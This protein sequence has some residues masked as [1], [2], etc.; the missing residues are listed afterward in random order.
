MGT[1]EKSIRLYAWKKNYQTFK[2][3][4]DE[5]GSRN[6]AIQL[7]DSTTPINLANC[8]VYF[9]AEKP[10][11]TTSYTECIKY[12]AGE[13][14]VG[15]TLTP[16]M[17]AVAGTVNCF[18]Q[19]IGEGK[20][21]LRFDGMTLEVVECNLTNSVESATEF[22]ALV[23]VL[24]R[25]ETAISAAEKSAVSAS[26]AAISAK[27]A[28]TS[29]AAAAYNA[30]TAATQATSASKSASDEALNAKEAAENAQEATQNA[31]TATQNAQAATNLARDAYD[32]AI[33]GAK[34]VVVSELAKRGQL[35]PE[36]VNSLEELQGKDASLLYVLPDGF[37]YACINSTTEGYWTDGYK[38]ALK[39]NA[40][41]WTDDTRFGG[42]VG[43]NTDSFL[44]N[45]IECKKGD[46][47]HFKNCFPYKLKYLSSTNNSW[48][49]PYY[50]TG[51]TST[52]ASY[53]SSVTTFVAGAV[54]TDGH[55]TDL[56]AI[57]IEFREPFN[58]NM[59][60]SINQNI[61][62][63]EAKYVE[64][65]SGYD[66]QNTGH[67]F[68]PA[69]YETEL[70]RHSTEINE[71]A[72]NISIL[73]GVTNEQDSR[74]QQ[75][76]EVIDTLE[77]KVENV[78][79]PLIPDYW[80]RSVDEAVE[81][82]KVLQA[83]GGKDIVNFVWF[84]DLHQGTSPEYT[85]NIGNLCAYLMNS[86]D[87]PLTLMS[88]DTLTQA[89]LNNEEA[90]LKDLDD[91][92]S[93]FNQIGL[94]RLMLIRGNHDDVYGYSG[95]GDNKVYYVNKVAPAKVWNKLHRPQANDFRKVFGDDGTY[96]Y[97]DNTP[98]KV[99]FICLNSNFYEGAAVSNGTANAMTFGFGNAQLDWLETVA[100]D[101]DEDWSVVI[102][103]H[104]PV[105]STYYLGL[106]N[107]GDAFMEIIDST[108]AHII[109]FF[110]GHAHQDGIYNDKIHQPN[111]VITCSANVPYD[112][113]E[114]TAGKA[115]DG[116][117][118]ETAIDIVSIDKRN[119]HIYMTRLGAGSD[120]ATEY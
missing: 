9:H 50:G 85:K 73:Q 34:N 45:Y 106:Y 75:A 87:I 30:S 22:S 31:L 26:T 108:S 119:R 97:L 95:S 84:S 16:Q 52:P 78:N 116:K 104:V 77:Q 8:S 13:G 55:T 57:Q 29:A 81:K 41:G 46:I 7:M 58:N 89:A 92:R 42:A 86:C 114:R 37:I 39:E 64:G 83:S 71:N 88:G 1:V 109:A 66:W 96:F 67:A 112:G 32:D 43:G 102:A 27:D 79:V 21:D 60:V 47:I 53:D 4:Q 101:V 19:V 93:I 11:S 113:T 49:G 5:V 35:K 110:S 120:R 103:T 105:I 82:V 3:V 14:L 51:I 70:E 74:L 117:V 76:E 98:Q 48:V 54:D 44:S 24:T 23:N 80:K 91:A 72:R 99:R 69:N 10:D 100:L 56:L 40:E 33:T 12:Q 20:T 118:T 115:V 25:A 68:V 38:N 107:D 17:C 18:I 65:S 94:E 90:V 59:I 2:V 28:T 36:F 61:E 62:G 6:F 111:V 15:L 63:E